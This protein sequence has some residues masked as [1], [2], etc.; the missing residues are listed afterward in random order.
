MNQVILDELGKRLDQAIEVIKRDF[1][2]VR[3]GRAK[4]S[5]IE[6]VKVEAY[7]SLMSIKELA[8]ISVPDPSL[9]VIAP[10]DRSL[11]G[12]IS[13]GIQKAGLNLQ[14]IVDGELVKI[15]IP[16]LTQERREELVKLIHQKLESGKVMVRQIRVEVKE[17]I[18]KLEGEGG[19]SEDD[20]KNW[21]ENMQKTIDQYMSKI[22]E[23]GRE[24]EKELM[25]L[26]WKR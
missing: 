13:T 16:S 3:S 9:I 2:S 21:L 23:L 8:T 7:S 1:S 25:T 14:P 24:K 6:D 18:E 20:I 10:W 19:V 17:K 22:E 15:A 4:P 26:W 11:I 12:A 5:L